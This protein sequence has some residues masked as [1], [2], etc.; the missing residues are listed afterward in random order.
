LRFI[1]KEP[2]TERALW[3]Q[4]VNLEAETDY[5]THRLE[6]ISPARERSARIPVHW[7]RIYSLQ[8]VFEQTGV[9]EVQTLAE[10]INTAWALGVQPLPQGNKV[11][12]ATNAGGA[13]A[14]FRMI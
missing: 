3:K 11:G 10:L 8:A 12:I 5:F 14:C 4:P 7:W 9:I 2:K 1:W 6:R 13:A